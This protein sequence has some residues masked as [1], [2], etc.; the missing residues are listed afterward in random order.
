[1]GKGRQVP[2]FWLQFRRNLLVDQKPGKT[3]TTM[4]Q[5][6]GAFNTIFTAH[7]LMKNQLKNTIFYAFTWY[8]HSIV[9]DTPTLRAR[10]SLT[11]ILPVT[12]VQVTNRFS[13]VRLVYPAP[14]FTI[15]FRSWVTRNVITIT[16]GRVI[17]HILTAMAQV[18]YWGA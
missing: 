18:I 1:M 8:H 3:A 9:I 12:T 5:L 11:L 6:M 17:T 10:I 13:P 15:R 16:T 4:G 7:K 2:L 14:H